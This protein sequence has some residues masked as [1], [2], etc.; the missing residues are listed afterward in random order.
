MMGTIG[1]WGWITTETPVA[2]K[3]FFANFEIAL[4]RNK[5][6]GTSP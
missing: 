2:K 4:S 5:K 3:V 6:S 1:L